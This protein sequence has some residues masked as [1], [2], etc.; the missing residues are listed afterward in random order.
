MNG[1]VKYPEDMPRK[2]LDFAS[3]YCNKITRGILHLPIT[4]AMKPPPNPANEKSRRD[5]EFHCVCIKH[6]SE[7][8]S[9]VEKSLRSGTTHQNIVFVEW[10]IDSL[11][12]LSSFDGPV[13]KHNCKTKRPKELA[14][15]ENVICRLLT[16]KTN[17]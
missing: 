9:L 14:S 15:H 5:F 6:K 11:S 12:D 7:G 10:V 8:K 2:M 16:S 1:P 17:E 3:H 4:P 13:R